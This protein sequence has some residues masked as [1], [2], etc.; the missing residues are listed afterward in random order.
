[1]KP[2]QY[3]IKHLHTNNLAQWGTDIIVFDTQEEAEELLAECPASYLLIPSLNVE[4][5]KGIFFIEKSINYKKLKESSV[6]RQMLRMHTSTPEYIFDLKE[7]N[8]HG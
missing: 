5:C 4:I 6:Y 1:M 8:K 7:E 3:I 2:Y